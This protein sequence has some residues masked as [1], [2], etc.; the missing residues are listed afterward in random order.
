MS[1]NAIPDTIYVVKA[2]GRPGLY[3]FGSTSN[4]SRRFRHIC[5]ASP[6]EMELI[7]FM[8]GCRDLERRIHAALISAHVRCE[9]FEPTDEV[10]AMAEAIAGGCIDLEALPAPKGVTSFVRGKP[11]DRRFMATYRPESAAA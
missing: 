5:N 4:L 10:R 8:P 7:G 2:A 9:W 3:K 11:V 6:V 1:I